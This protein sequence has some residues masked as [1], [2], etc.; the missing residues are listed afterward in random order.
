MKKINA[1]VLGSMV[2]A[3]SC[4]APEKDKKAQLAE[5][6]TELRELNTKIKSLEAEIRKEDPSFGKT[7]KVTLVTTLQTAPAAFEHFVEVRGIVASDRNVNLTAQTPGIIKQ[8]HI[9]E[10][11][12]VRAGQSLVT[13]DS[14]I[15]QNS[16]SELKTAYDLA[17]TV[18]E[19][20]AN[21]WKQKIGTEIQ[22]LQA[23]NN[24]ESLERKISTLKSQLQQTVITAPFSGTIDDVNAKVGE[25]AQPGYGIIRMVSLN[26]MYIQAEVSEA[27]IGKFKKGDLVK[28]E[29]PSLG[30]ELTSEVRAVGQVINEQNRTFSLEV[31]LPESD[32]LIKPNALAVLKIRDEQHENVITV[33]TKLILNDNQGD[34]IFVVENGSA[35][36]VYVERGTTYNGRTLIKT[37]LKGGEKIVNDGF[38][39]VSG[40]DKVKEVNA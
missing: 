27:F 8:V 15:M 4:S 35:K 17:K 26:K 25:M 23:K 12:F 19:K 2:V 5:Y 33:P 18:Y 24:K 40:G 16:L 32:A 11:D 34:Y 21:L 7:D 39:M 30:K 37:G 1:L 6:K 22:Y 13:L 14:E 20:Q 29:F 3:A 28:V 38:R 10:G 9:E 31:A 36:K